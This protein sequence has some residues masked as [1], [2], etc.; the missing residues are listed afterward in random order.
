[1]RPVLRSQV[2]SHQPEELLPALAFFE[3]AQDV[4]ID[5]PLPGDWGPYLPV[6]PDYLITTRGETAC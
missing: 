3:N 6:Q 5:A 1:M 2:R 4:V